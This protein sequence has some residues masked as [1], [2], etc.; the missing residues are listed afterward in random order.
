MQVC[1]P[2]LHISLGV[3]HKLFNLFEDACHKLDIEIAVTEMTS[4]GV[5]MAGHKY[6]K[7]V[8]ANQEITEKNEEASCHEQAVMALEQLVTWMCLH[9][10][11]GTK[12]AIEQMNKQI[13]E[14]NQRAKA[15]VN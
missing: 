8:E 9:G 11:E 4:Q 13:S 7:F 6:K 2:G 5:A 10:S 14:S 1:I 15:L 3:F 12:P